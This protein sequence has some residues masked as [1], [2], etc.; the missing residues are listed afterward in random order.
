MVVI[1]RQPDVPRQYRYKTLLTIK[2]PL[3]LELRLMDELAIKYLKT[4]QVWHHRRLLLTHMS[5]SPSWTSVSIIKKELSF[6]EDCFHADS[7]N[8]HTWSY[9]QWLL[10]HFN[11][12]ELWHGELPFV[13]RL[14]SED[15]RNNSAWHH[16]FFAVFDSGVRKGEEDRENI[17]RREV[18]YVVSSL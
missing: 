2:S 16:R 18:L 1:I 17:I 10:A 12:D 13:E 9:R 5:S 14:L 6:I 11:Y 15:V 8:Y 4:Y 7:K 3:D